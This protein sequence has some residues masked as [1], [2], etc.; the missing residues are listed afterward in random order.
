MRLIRLW[1]LPWWQEGNIT[2]INEKKKDLKTKLH[3]HGS[4]GDV[5]PMNIRRE[6]NYLHDVVQYPKYK[7]LRLSSASECC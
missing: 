5:A 7:V 6:T 1:P 3:M 2:I 4:I